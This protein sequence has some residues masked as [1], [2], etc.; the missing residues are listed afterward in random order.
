MLEIPINDLTINSLSTKIK[1]LQS[2][3]P[4]IK[5][6][7][8]IVKADNP[9]RTSKQNRALHSTLRAFADKL[10]EAGQTET[11]VLDKIKQQ[12]GF[13]LTWNLNTLKNLFNVFSEHLNKKTSSKLTTSEL[14][15]TY[16]IF[17]NSINNLTGIYQEWHS[18]EPPL[19]GDN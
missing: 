9:Q 8:L 4:N 6:K 2:Q 12:K 10:N 11:I 16:E 1:E 14:I 19:L 13:E 15:K 18:I 3:N 5:L 17:N 7:C